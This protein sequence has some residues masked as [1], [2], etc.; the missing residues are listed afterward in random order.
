MRK[1]KEVPA[2]SLG[3]YLLEIVEEFWKFSRSSGQQGALFI[4]ES[5]PV[6]SLEPR[7][8]NNLLEAIF[9]FCPILG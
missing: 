6:E 4:G 3:P 7:V 8:L 9:K 5:F 2:I 1:E